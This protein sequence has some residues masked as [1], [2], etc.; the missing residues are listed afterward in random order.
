M[1]K[2]KVSLLFITL[3]TC[4]SRDEYPQTINPKNIITDSLKC[5]KDSMLFEMKINLEKAKI[6]TDN[7]EKKFY[8]NK[9][10][11]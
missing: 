5:R 6:K 9:K 4:V 11:H 1:I 10:K 2:L 7:L 3:L 8:S